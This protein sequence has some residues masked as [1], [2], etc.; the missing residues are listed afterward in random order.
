MAEFST[1]LTICIREGN[2]EIVL[3]DHLQPAFPANLGLNSLVPVL[4][5]G[6]GERLRFVN[7]VKTHTVSYPDSSAQQI[8]IKI[9]SS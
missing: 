9:A 6:H 3:D 8:G 1:G 2:L 4:I 5:R 7:F